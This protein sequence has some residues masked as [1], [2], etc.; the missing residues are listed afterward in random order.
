[1][2]G[3]FVRN[4]ARFDVGTWTTSLGVELD[5][6]LRQVSDAISILMGT[7]STPT[8][9]SPDNVA[10]GGRGPAPALD[11]HVHAFPV[12]APV[13]LGNSSSEGTSD[14]GVRGDHVHKRDVRVKKA[15]AD[16]GTR[17]ALNLIEGAGIALTVA[18]NPGSDQVDVT[19]ATTTTATDD[20]EVFAYFMS[21]VS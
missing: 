14:S 6:V 10:D 21:R 19:V 11:D 2:P 8:D 3:R 13:G 16:V 1:M 7:P 9:V 5:R 15:S 17:N 4:R 18:D 20:A 12:S